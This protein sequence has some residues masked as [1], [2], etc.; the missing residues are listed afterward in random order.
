LDDEIKADI[1]KTIAAAKDQFK[2]EKST[3][4]AK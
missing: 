3:A 4:A 2:S 1:N